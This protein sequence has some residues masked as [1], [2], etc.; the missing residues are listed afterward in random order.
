MNPFIEQ[1]YFFLI[2]YYLH[3]WLIEVCNDIYITNRLIDYD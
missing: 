1:F 3:F 2:T